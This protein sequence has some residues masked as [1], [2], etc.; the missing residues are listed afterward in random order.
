MRI[1]GVSTNDIQFIE[2]HG[3]GT[4]VG[5]PIEVNAIAAAFCK[6]RTTALYIGSVKSNLGHAEAAAGICLECL[7][8]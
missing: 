7:L 1:T 6:E 4:Q 2:A 8:H 3:T 5:D